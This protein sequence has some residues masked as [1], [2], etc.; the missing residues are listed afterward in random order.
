MAINVQHLV[1]NYGEQRAVDNLS[2]EIGTGEIVGFLGPNG[3]GKS[4]TMKMITGYIPPTSG[5][6]M[7]NTYDIQKDTLEIRK[8]IGYLPEHNPLYLDMFVEELLEFV[9][10]I[11]RLPT[12]LRK[13]RIEQ[14]IEMTG[15]LREKHKKIGML[16]KGYRQRVGLAQAL[17]HDPSILILDEP[18]SG[19][20]PNQIIEIRNLV[21]NIGRNKTVIFSSHILSEVEAIADR[22]MIIHRGKLQVDQP[23][24]EL[25]QGEEE[26]S[27]IQLEVEKK[28]I[29]ITE[30]EN[31]AGVIHTELVKPNQFLIHTKDDLVCRKQLFQLCVKKDNP[32]LSLK[33]EGSSLEQTFK[34]YTS[35]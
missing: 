28:G 10:R 11:Y 19:L 34:R 25:I 12:K 7:V 31:F 8:Q 15:L 4:T 6:I 35:D 9:S 17:I 23:L 26:F 22:V 1:K 33:V 2:F 5:S 32:I 18:T 21:K 24:S 30:L 14:V 3:A 27:I 16:S 29:I 13:Q 20:D